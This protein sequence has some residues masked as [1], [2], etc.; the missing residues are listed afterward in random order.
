MAT[1]DDIA[2]ELGISKSTVSK[3]LNGAKDVSKLMRQTILEK[4]VELGY[5]RV[6]RSTTGPKIAIFVMNMDY[7]KP[8]DFGYDIVVGFRKAAEPAG[9]RI[10]VIMLD[11]KLQ[12]KMHYDEYMVL[13]GFSGGLF[14]GLS[15]LDPWIQDFRSCKTPTVLYDNHVPG[16]PNVSDIGVDNAAGMEI[17]VR[18]LQSLGHTKIGFLS[19]ALGAYVYQQRYYAFFRAMEDCGLSATNDTVG[20]SFHIT[21]CLSTH[22]PR[23]LNNGCTAIMCSHDMLAHSVMV[24]CAVLGLSIPGDISIMGFD[25]IPLCRYTS[26]PLTTIRQDRAN[27]GKSAFYA[28]SC[29]MNHV[30]LSSL[31][32]QAQLVERA[33]CASVSQVR[34]QPSAEGAQP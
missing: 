3:A 25:D 4:A 15:L 33:S 16:N 18:Y 2:R 28:M 21:E 24:Q 23:L 32:L 7:R 12:K 8:E 10:E 14:L 26:P 29:V 31:L 1:L 9:F 27:L 6:Q 20:S 5:S 13:G 11:Q 22:L 30:P 34:K 19:S 17:A